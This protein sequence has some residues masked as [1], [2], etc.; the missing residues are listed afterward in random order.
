MVIGRV[1]QKYTREASL[2]SLLKHKSLKKDRV[3]TK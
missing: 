2:D 1:G 3:K